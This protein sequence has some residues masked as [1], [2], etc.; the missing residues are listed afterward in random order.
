MT[1]V[2]VDHRNRPAA[3]ARL[4]TPPP[5]LRPTLRLVRPPDPGEPQ[6]PAT[7]VVQHPGW[8][9]AG[10][11][12]RSRICEKLGALASSAVVVLRDDCED[13]E[14]LRIHVFIAGLPSQVRE[15]SLRELASST[16]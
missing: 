8:F 7:V 3:R 11:E 9:P 1:A 14:T 10:D 4:A 12:L 15:L 16:P 2:A 5:R 13:P 6:P